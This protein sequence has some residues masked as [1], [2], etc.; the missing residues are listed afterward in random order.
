[1]NYGDFAHPARRR[2]IKRSSTPHPALHSEE[3]SNGAKNRVRFCP[4][5]IAIDH[6]AVG[7]LEDELG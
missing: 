5:R 7:R 3:K 6:L 4:A 1:M 2:F